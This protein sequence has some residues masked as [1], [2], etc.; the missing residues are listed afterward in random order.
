MPTFKPSILLGLALLLS[1][2][3]QAQET[4]PI[5]LGDTVIMPL[6]DIIAKGLPTLV[7]ET[8]NQEEPSC[9]YVYA[10][11]G[12]LGATIRNATKVPSRLRIFKRLNNIDSV[13]YDSGEYE[14]STSGMTI[15]IRGNT[16]AFE[17]KKPYKIKLEKK[18]DL[19]FRGNEAVF[20]DKEWLLLKDEYMLTAAGFKVSQLLGMTWI[21]GCCNVNVII[22]NDYRGVY[23]L[24]ESV[25]RN[26]DCRLD[27]D[28]Y[29]GYIFE[30]DPYWW[31]EDVYV[32]SITSPKY[33][34]TFKYPDSDDITSEQLE[35]MQTMVTQYENSLSTTQY[36]QYIDVESFAAWCLVNDIMGTKDA[37][38][39]N[40]YYTKYD[41]TS[42]SR[43]VMPLAWDFGMA[44]R[45]A[46]AWS[47]SHT[48][49]M[50]VLFNNSN[51]LFV[52]TYV[53]LWRKCGDALVEEFNR[54]MNI[55]VNSAEGVALNKSY[56]LDRI[57]WGKPQYINSVTYLRK[58]W[59]NERAPWITQQVNAMNPRG[60]LNVNGAVDMDD[61]SSL[62]NILLGD[63]VEYPNAS[64][65]NGDHVVNMDDL[66]SLINMLLSM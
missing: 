44:E 25:K 48:E 17:P 56:Q 11:S 58:K 63:E 32:S 51:R 26:P 41:S 45:T 64:D 66:S 22:N 42:D 50:N 28:K 19:L 36:P 15:K 33:N 10:P 31:N 27:V 35:Y 52:D 8:V 37:G 61:L 57:V 54:Y 24:C 2:P 23:L 59:I 46:A 40:R 14:P 39:A 16:S 9:E 5:T 65:V 1:W 4:T 6:T 12:S 47:S 60:D 21:P 49:H 53:G 7:I 13:L 38:G 34:F 29:C 3:V 43:I 62:I 18:H 20:K 30:C 55:F